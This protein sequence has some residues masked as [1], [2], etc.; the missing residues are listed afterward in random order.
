MEESVVTEGLE[1]RVVASDDDHAFMSDHSL[2]LESITGRFFA[3]EFV[4]YKNQNADLEEKVED[5][6]NEGDAVAKRAKV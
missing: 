1:L 5:G 6:G 2:T 3:E 4:E